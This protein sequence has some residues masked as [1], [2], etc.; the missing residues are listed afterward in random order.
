MLV[1]YS[2]ASKT[3][4]KVTLYCYITKKCQ[5]SLLSKIHSGKINDS[6]TKALKTTKDNHD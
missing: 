5:C 4:A 6:R 1:K 3:A 2:F